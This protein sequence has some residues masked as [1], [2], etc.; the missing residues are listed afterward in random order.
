MTC[1]EQLDL[2]LPAPS[3]DDV[4]RERLDRLRAILAA[5]ASLAPSGVAEVEN[6]IERIAVIL[7]GRP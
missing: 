7:R 2:H 6:E 4:L 5:N 1:D 3:A